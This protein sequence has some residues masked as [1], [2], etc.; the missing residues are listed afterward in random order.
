[1]WKEE[2]EKTRD[3]GASNISLRVTLIHSNDAKTPYERRLLWCLEPTTTTSWLNATAITTGL[4]VM[5]IIWI[6]RI[7]TY[8]IGV[9]YGHETP[10]VYMVAREHDVRNF[11]IR[12]LHA[13]ESK[14]SGGGDSVRPGTYV[15]AC[16]TYVGPPRGTKA[17][18]ASRDAPTF[19]RH[20]AYA[21]KGV[22]KASVQSHSIRLY[23]IPPTS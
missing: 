21:P 19:E 9:H 10:D 4:K 14:A 6:K 15:V 17:P 18:S 1:M 22:L 13:L 16:R 11:T 7:N 20:L 3:D 23:T 8:D 2:E 12:T 5:R